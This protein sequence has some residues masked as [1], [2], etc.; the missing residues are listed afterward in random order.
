MSVKLLNLMTLLA[1]NSSEKTI[2]II[3]MVILAI[4]LLVLVVDATAWF[5]SDYVP[6]SKGYKAFLVLF[7]FLAMG[8]AVILFRIYY[9]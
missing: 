4:M 1:Q 5:K 2:S 7:F 8:A 9:K 3:S 6:R